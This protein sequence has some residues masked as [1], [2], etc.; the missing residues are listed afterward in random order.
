[1]T[2]VIYMYIIIRLYK[3]HID[4][5][6]QAMCMRPEEEGWLTVGLPALLIVDI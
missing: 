4:E 5:D 3:R 1:M 6:L 2:G